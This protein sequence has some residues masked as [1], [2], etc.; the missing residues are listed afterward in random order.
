M[1]KECDRYKG[2]SKAEC[3]RYGKPS[4][5]AHYTADDVHRYRRDAELCFICGQPATDV[6]HWPA[7]GKSAHGEWTLETPNGW[8]V[9]KPSLFALCRKCHSRFHANYLTADWV[10]DTEQAEI[11]YWNGTITNQRRYMPGSKALYELGHW[12]FSSPMYKTTKGFRYREVVGEDGQWQAV[13]SA[14]QP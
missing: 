11:D 14:I 4:I 1:K 10:W 3:E 8:H 7:I 12:E 6:H 2:R 9:M 5:G 13:R